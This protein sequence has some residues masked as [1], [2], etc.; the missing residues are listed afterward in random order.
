MD[1]V[2]SRP[3][4]NAL[5]E[6]ISGNVAAQEPSNSTQRTVEIQGAVFGHLGRDLVDDVAV[7]TVNGGL[8]TWIF[9]RSGMA[10]QYAI[11]SDG[12][13]RMQYVREDGLLYAEPQLSK[14]KG[15]NVKVA[16]E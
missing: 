4:D 12:Q 15:K 3:H 14:D 11:Y 2:L 7:N 16:T 9:C 8:K 6:D 1:D 13:T 5:T 10:R